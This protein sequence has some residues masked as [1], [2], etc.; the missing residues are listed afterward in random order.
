[1]TRH[2]LLLGLLLAALAGGTGGLRAQ[3]PASGSTTPLVGRVVD[4]DG[5]FPLAEA[6]VSLFRIP[7]GAIVTDDL[8]DHPESLG[9]PAGRVATG[10]DGGYRFDDL[11]PGSYLLQ[12]ERLGYRTA[13][14][15]VR[16]F[17]PRSRVSVALRVQPIALEPLEVRGT[18]EVEMR[19]A[20]GEQVALGRVPAVELRQRL[21]L[22]SDARTVSA[23]DLRESATL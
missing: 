16:A 21:L 17:G 14:I 23:P 6:E 4:A 18:G 10:D 8:L 3:T 19:N 12:V 7:G 9:P 11:P 22:A 5:G 2:P 13:T 15:R 1:M 20:S